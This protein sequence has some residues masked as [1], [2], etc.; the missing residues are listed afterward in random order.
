MIRTSMGMALAAVAVLV[1]GEVL[2]HAERQSFFPAD[3]HERPTYRPLLP[4][5][6]VLRL[7]V[8]K[9]PGDEGVAAGDDSA[10]R[11]ARIANDPLR[12]VNEQLLRECAFEH[13]QAAVDAVTT[14]GTTIYVL[15]GLYREQPSIR[16]LDERAGASHPSD[17]AFCEAV[18]ARGP[19]RLTYEEQVRCR[20]IQNT[21][22]IFGD[23]N[24]TDDNCGAD[25][26]GV[27]ANPATQACNP[28]QSAC[29]YYDLQ[30]EGTG[31]KPTDVIFEGDFI[32]S[33][34]GAADDGQFRYLNGIRADRADGIYLRNFT[35]QIY[36][37]NAIYVLET[38]GAVMDR[39]LS[40][41]VD[42][43]AY[44]SF[45][46][47][48]V[49][50][51]T[52]D[53]YGAADS[54]VYPGS[55]A[56]IYK[57]ATHANANLR[58]RQG[59]EV[60][61]S[62]GRH[63]AGGYSGTAGNSPW[64]HDS[65]FFKNQTGLATESIFGGHPG[66]PQDHGL[67]E[68]NQINNNNKNYFA[69]VEDDG[70]C[71]AQTPRDRGVVPPEFREFDALPPEVQEAI[72]DRMVLC[73]GI[74]FPTGAGMV[75]GG[76]NYDVNQNNQMWDNWRYGYM[77]FH[78]PTSLR[79][80]E[81]G[82]DEYALA[83]PYDNS[84]FDRFLTNHFA[85]NALHDPPLLQPNAFDFW[86]DNSGTGHCFDGNTSFDA[87]VTSS[88]SDSG[89]P[90]P[91]PGG[92][93]TDGPVP[94]AAGQTAAAQNDRIA[95]LA[96]CIAY[97]RT[98][99]STKSPECPFFD[100][101]VAPPNRQNVAEVLASQPPAAE[102]GLGES[103]R[104][105]YFVL[106]NDSGSTHDVSTVT[107]A[108]EGP[109]EYLT[110]LTLS[111]TLVQDGQVVTHTAEVTDVTG[112]NVFTFATP[113]A[114]PAVNYVLFD[115]SADTGTTVALGNSGAMLASGGWLAVAL[116]LLAGGPRKRRIA[117]WVTL[118]LAGTTLVSSCSNSASIGGGPVKFTLTAVDV[119]DGGGPVAYDG[120]PKAIGSLRL[121]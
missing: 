22:A 58:A 85:E 8:C 100:P 18:L 94:D 15:P 102:V 118:V 23:P 91:L 47:D 6:Q 60:R 73:P 14:R 43:Y 70:P 105:G 68:N 114:M 27:C 96:S 11:I 84:Y 32:T 79:Y 24:F 66:M 74:P 112:S 21:V 107:I 17:T 52:V 101:L 55:G 13:L 5:P 25:T 62:T 50:Y 72:L 109:V 59:T 115:L 119:S 76:G 53:G 46:S 51:D 36:E 54:V 35:A 40:R 10:S 61:N 41:W 111:V 87:A 31:D 7:V 108:A 16:A 88:T 104:T 106:N 77:L 3:R 19:G 93:C 20:H 120:L 69:F 34:P 26:E 81:T 97:D 30:I 38:D 57:N 4:D 103:G 33:T 113:V 39:L 49:L 1:T 29:Q 12:A 90:I 63:A 83:N 9:Q 2:A 65:F 80:T 95:F 28:E 75:I 99:P 92:P 117:L 98:D 71:I 45:A 48:R 64:V 110:G 82:P 78:V 42:E 56:D 86:F 116:A 89:A 121:K 37:F 44:L 67:F